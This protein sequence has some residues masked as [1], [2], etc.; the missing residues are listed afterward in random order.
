MSLLESMAHGLVPVVSD[1]ESGIREV[2]DSNNGI[3]V[4][5]D[6]IPGYAKA[7][8]HLHEK[9]GCAG[10]HGAI[11]AGHG[12]ESFFCSRHGGPV[13]GPGR[14][15]STGFS[16][17]A[18]EIQYPPDPGVGRTNQISSR[19]QA[20]KTAWKDYDRLTKK[21]TESF[22]PRRMRNLHVIPPATEFAATSLCPAEPVANTDCPSSTTACQN[23]YATK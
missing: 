2:V 18:W 21:K 6:D 8:I 23:Q 7:I 16:R 12:F 10:S 19:L 5:I 20:A 17:M 14:E 9:Q 4:A 22:H 3:R 15:L 11:C 1:I 13:A